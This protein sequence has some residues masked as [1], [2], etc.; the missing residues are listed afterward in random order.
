MPVFYAHSLPGAPE[1]QWQKLEDHLRQV[2]ALAL[3]RGEWFNAGSWAEAAGLLHDLGKAS[4]AFQNR[5]RGGPKADHSTA[6]AQEALALFCTLNGKLLAYI[7]AGH[8]GGMPDGVSG[9]GPDI[10]K[11]LAQKRPPLDAP[12]PQSLKR[13]NLPNP[14]IKDRGNFGF[15]VS[16][17]IRMLFSC[18]VDA[19]Y[20]DTEAFMNPERSGRRPVP[21]GLEELQPRMESFLTSLRAKAGSG[22][23]NKKR[24]QILDD[25]LAA[26]EKRPGIYSLTVPTG[27]GKTI[28]SLAFALKHA[29]LQGQRRIIYTIPYTSIIEQNA[30]VF[31]QILGDEAVLEHHS[32]LPVP[33]LDDTRDYERYT[34]TRLACENWDAP[35]VVTTNVQLFESLYS[36]L[37]SRCRKLHNLAG[38]VIV[39]DEAQMMPRDALMPCLEALSELGTNYNCTVLLCTATQPALGDAEVFKTASLHPVEIA[40]EPERTF[41]SFKRVQSVYHPE[42]ID[43]AELARRLASEEQ[44]LCIVNTRR[45]GPRSL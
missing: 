20:L 42:P 9:T 6:G 13:I 39:L 15:S 21:P 1:S 38:S 4:S 8:H 19:D 7:V 29:R 40:K 16:F 37:P 35:L 23:L 26:S 5:L 44:V 45:Q 24:N 43:Q 28:S 30:A 36:N 11:R 18:L 41:K 3:E 17:F 22:P 34:R 32:N 2:A 12:V 31:R 27:G 10:V 25:C 33:D 14:A